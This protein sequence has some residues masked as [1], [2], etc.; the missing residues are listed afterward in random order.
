MNAPET[1]APAYLLITPARN[2]SRYIRRT[3]ES[4]V[5]QTVPP[6]LWLIADDGSTDDTRA[7]AEEYAARFPFIRVVGVRTVKIGGPRG[8]LNRGVDAAVFNEALAMVDYSGFDYLG[9]LDADVE[10]EPDYYERVLAEFE[11]DE[12]LGIC[13]GHFYEYRDGVLTLSK[14]P[15]WHVRG[16]GKVYRR[17]CFEAIGGIEDIL[18]W[19]AIDEV[20]AQMHGWCSRALHEPKVTHLR[21]TGAADGILTGTARLGLCD[22]ILHYHPLFILPRTAKAA[23]TPPYVIGAFAYLYGYLRA[24]VT[25]PVRY[26]DPEV[27]RFIQRSQIARMLGRRPYA[28]S[29]EELRQR[30]KR[31]AAR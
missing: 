15:D 16:G 19:D 27:I 17:A 10:F 21:P 9:K 3:C 5:R 23:V 12:C 1:A 13:A 26:D 24:C 25:R 2:E 11:K 4:V 14:V 18:N 7:I 31:R 28:M 22:Y 8:R 29:C 30:G 20:K 6:A